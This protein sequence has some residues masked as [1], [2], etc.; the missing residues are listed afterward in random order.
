[1][2]TN[3]V[4][5]V[6]D[7][8]KV[9]GTQEIVTALNENNLKTRFIDVTL[10]DNGE[11]L[12]VD[13]ECTATAAICYCQICKKRKYIL[14]DSVDCEITDSGT[15]LI[16]IDDLGHIGESTLLIEL[17]VFDENNAQVLV[18]PYPICARVTSSILNEADVTPESEGT[19]PELLRECQEALANRPQ[20]NG[21]TLTGNQTGAAL[22]L[23]DALTVGE[24]LSLDEN[25]V[26]S[27]NDKSFMI[28]RDALPNESVGI[29]DKSGFTTI[30]DDISEYTVGDVRQIPVNV[31][32]TF[33]RFYGEKV[34]TEMYQ[35][36]DSRLFIK[37]Y[38]K[39]GNHWLSSAWKEITI[40][41]GLFLKVRTALPAQEVSDSGVSGF[42]PV[43]NGEVQDYTIGET[44]QLPEASAGL[45]TRTYNAAHDYAF[46]TYQT[47]AGKT[48][49][50]MHTRVAVL[51]NVNWLS[52]PWYSE[53]Q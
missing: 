14:N 34:C 11:Q 40:D 18:L 8:N 50:R 19:I 43:K 52:T 6:Y 29:A 10:I 9:R 16:P 13:R 38:K 22:G 7:M 49:C 1:M 42:E 12:Q 33:F 20:I 24:Y 46:D 21:H 45:F 17:S 47:L 39:V 5:I 4:S 15:V 25:G 51:D 36:T 44:G 48:Y 35:T 32:G 30:S 31:S 28:E 27:L 2:R 53:G 41:D 26:L 37:N 3:P 23:Q